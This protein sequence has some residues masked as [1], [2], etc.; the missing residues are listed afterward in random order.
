MNANH[1]NIGAIVLFKLDMFDIMDDKNNI[2]GW[3]TYR[4]IYYHKM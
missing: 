4:S 1:F 2:I 3:L